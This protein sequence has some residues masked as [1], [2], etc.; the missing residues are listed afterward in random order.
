MRYDQ[1]LFEQSC[2]LLEEERNRVIEERQ[3]FCSPHLRKNH[4]PQ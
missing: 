3:V 1:E 4:Y 2:R